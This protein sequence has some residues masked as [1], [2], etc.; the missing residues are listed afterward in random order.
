MR[1]IKRDK[2]KELSYREQHRFMV[3]HPKSAAMFRAA[4]DSLL[5]GVPMNWMRKWAGAF[6]IFLARANA[7]TLRMWTG[8]STWTCVWVIRV[9]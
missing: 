8:A 4:Q 3:E 2:L 6:P 1:V 9:R 7:P 5:G